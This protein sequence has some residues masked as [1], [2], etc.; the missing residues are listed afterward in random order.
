MKANR[1]RTG[2]E[3]A[4]VGADHA[5]SQIGD[6]QSLILE[7]VFDEFRHRPVEEHFRRFGIVA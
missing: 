4:R 1:R 6:L 2:I 5:L 7:I 3:R